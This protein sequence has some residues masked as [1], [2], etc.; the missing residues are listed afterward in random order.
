MKKK[1]SVKKQK[2]ARTIRKNYSRKSV[3]KGGKTAV[4]STLLSLAIIFI[5]GTIIYSNSFNC[6]FHLDDKTSIL[7]NIAIQDLSDLNAIWNYSHGR[8]IAYLTFAVNYHFGEL[9]VEGYHLFNLVVHLF[10]ASLIYWL[11]MMIFSSPALKTY[12]IIKDKKII[13]FITALLFVSHPLA[14]Q[15]VTY[16]VQRLA[17][18]VT[19]FYLLSVASYIK[20]RLT[21]KG[22]LAKYGMLALALI[23]AGL[24]M[25]TKQNAFTL[26]FTIILV[27]I[28]FFQTKQF[29]IEV[30]NYPIILIIA[31]FVGIT[32]I[33]LLN[34]SFSSIFSPLA[35]VPENNFTAI[36]PLNY[37]YTQFSVI[38]K[39]IQLLI[40]PINQNLD[41]DYRLSTGFFEARTILSFLFLLSL[42]IIAIFQ[43]KKNRLFTFGIFWFLI[44]LS[45][46]SSI[47]PIH[48]LIFE[49]RTYLPSFGFFII[50]TSLLYVFLWKKSKYV[51]IAILLIIIGSNSFLTYERNKV[52]KSE[53]SLLND[54]ISK[55]PNKARGYNNRG[56][57]F[58]LENKYDSAIQ[59]FNRAIELKPNY[60]LAYYN[61]G[62]VFRMQ[63]NFDKAI[64]DYTKAIEL[65]P[66]YFDAYSNRANLLQRQNKFDRA[67]HDYNRAIELEPKYA[68]T[69]F[70]RGIVFRNENKFN[71]AIQDYNKAIV[72]NP[73]FFEAYNARGEVYLMLKNYSAAIQDLNK[74]ITLNPG[75]IKAHI[76]RGIVHLQTQKYEEG[77][78]DFN[79]A[80]SLNPN[81]GIAY[82]NRG[83]AENKL[84]NR[85]SA[86]RDFQ[87]AIELGQ[88]QV[89]NWDG[90]QSCQ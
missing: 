12:T 78:Q 75:Y 23:S 58:Q 53:I 45:V 86:C 73:D 41:Y 33:A 49:H 7:D 13:A 57:H 39:Y 55:S 68:I 37:L 28:C 47:I 17:S 82:A 48:D 15:S 25:H 74:S 8:F 26:P 65:N 27:E 63:N 21:Q 18:L 88:R 22:V 3:R 30:K 83:L 24:A 43:Y 32:F 66:G 5:L 40:L 50:L 87:R 9:N 60:A 34:Y 72:L 36:S 76:N 10:N 16:I 81:F 31:A 64:Q 56:F 1:R 52:W 79:K 44:T 90:Y 85:E 20:S 89:I 4:P 77:V 42:I 80:I 11:T 61:R 69:Y 71:K 6:A 19:L 14:T 51:A 29:S 2:K 70:N 35:P 84:G 38:I 54:V 62:V 46:E 67:M 59:D